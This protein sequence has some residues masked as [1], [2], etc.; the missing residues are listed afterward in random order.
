MPV[1]ALPKDLLCYILDTF[2]SLRPFDR[3]ALRRCNL[4]SRA[5]RAVARQSL[6]RSIHTDLY[7]PVSVGNRWSDARYRDDIRRRNVWLYSEPTRNLL[8]LLASDPALSSQVRHVTLTDSNLPFEWDVERVEGTP[9]AS[10]DSLVGLVP[11]VDSFTVYE[12]SLF[13]AF[14]SFLA[15]R[16]VALEVWKGDWVDLADFRKLRSLDIDFS[17]I[18]REPLEAASL[19]SFHIG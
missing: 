14:R 18:E 1:P 5:F 8:H 3:A 17:N 19:R 10:V 6:Y 15:A 2:D 12:P 4:V 9:S 11:N 16:V 13:E 7:D